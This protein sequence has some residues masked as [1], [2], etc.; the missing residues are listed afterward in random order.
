[1][2]LTV[3]DCL[4]LSHGT[5]LQGETRHDGT[6]LLPPCVWNLKDDYELEENC[7][8]EEVTGWVY[9][10]YD[11]GRWCM[12]ENEYQGVFDTK[13]EAFEDARQYFECDDD[14]EDIRCWDNYYNEFV[15]EATDGHIV[16]T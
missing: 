3:K 16:G 10:W 8:W 4:E 2:A 5:F 1:M 6:V 14:E 13:K 12:T 11:S 9:R 15:K 7:S